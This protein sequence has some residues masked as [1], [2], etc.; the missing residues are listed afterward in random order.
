MQ[1]VKSSVADHVNTGCEMG[2]WSGWKKF[3][4]KAQREIEQK[5]IFP[6]DFSRS[7]VLAA[8]CCPLPGADLQQVDRG[9]NIRQ[10]F[11]VWDA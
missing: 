10:V 3:I 4:C 9:K 11:C 8:A 1:G 5:M 2:I 7:R 6:T